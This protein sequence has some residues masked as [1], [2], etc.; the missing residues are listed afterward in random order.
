MA[1]LSDMPAKTAKLTRAQRSR[2]VVLAEKKKVGLGGNSREYELHEA[3]VAAGYATVEWIG[4]TGV[5][6]WP[7]YTIT[8]TGMAEVTHTVE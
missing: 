7:V 2:L 8:D 4:Y 3:L 6:M 5:S 1:R